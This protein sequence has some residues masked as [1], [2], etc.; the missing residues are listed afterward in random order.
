[1]NVQSYACIGDP[2]VEVDDKKLEFG[3][4][5]VSG[6]PEYIIGIYWTLL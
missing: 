6:Y 2:N 4:H 3:Q 1:M 5:I